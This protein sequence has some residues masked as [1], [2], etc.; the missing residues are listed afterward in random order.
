MKVA[1]V[2]AGIVGLATTYELVKRG[3]DVTCF[4]AAEPMSARSL[5]ETR[6]FRLA[7]RDAVLVDH[8]R[9]SRALWRDWEEHSG[10]S[11][12]GGQ[13]AVVSGGVALQWHEAMLQA[14]VDCELFDGPTGL[15]V[16][17]KRSDGPYLRDPSG[18]VIAA[19][20]AGEFLRRQVG[21]RVL[22]AL[23]FDIE[24]RGPRAALY[25]HLRPAGSRIDGELYVGEF[26]QVVIVAG[27]ATAPL[28]AR[29][30]L[31]TP[32][33]LEHHARFGFRLRDRDAKPLCWL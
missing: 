31:Y 2:G 4:E 21:D 7:H 29:V 16:P 17:T 8:A 33:E 15:G 3:I 10:E 19:R 14:G 24:T 20:R 12:I 18:G 22:R 32:T 27:A 25:A 23:I 13:G 5:G 30:G 9:R 1:I 28:A 11:L 6:I 26:D